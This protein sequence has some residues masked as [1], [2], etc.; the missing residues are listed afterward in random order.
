MTGSHA[1]PFGTVCRLASLG[2]LCAAG[3]YAAEWQIEIAEPMG[4]LFS[5]LQFDKLGNAHVVHAHPP[6][7]A[8]KYSFWDRALGKWFTTT[9]DE[10]AGFCSLTLDSQQRPHVSYISYGTYRVNY[11]RWNGTEWDKQAIQIRA[12]Q[13]DYYTSIALDAKDNPA[14]SF[15]EYHGMGEEHRLNLRQVSWNGSAWEVRTI[16]STKG[17]GKFNSI[18]VDSEGHPHV[19]YANVSEGTASLRYGRWNGRS[20]D[21]ELLEGGVSGYA[22]WS[23]KLALDKKD[24]PH[25]TYTDVVSRLVK[26]A[27][28]RGSKWELETVDAIEK[29]GY[30]DRNGL[31]LDDEGR[32]YISYYDAGLGQLRMAHKAEGRWVTEVVDP[33]AAGYT[34]SIGIDR[35]TIWITYSDEAQRLK[36][37]RRPLRL[38]DS[39]KETTSASVG[40]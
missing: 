5:S 16:D 20:W 6:T 35:D 7:R 29:E 32:P 21:L 34:S 14:I 12:R 27:V 33:E 38:D 3:V 28:K 11:A 30:P 17:S 24:V 39:T 8:L 40:K 25:I 1:Y 15:Y 4:G 31:A 22:A 37:A 36:S 23:V 10:T 26:Y 2:V 9:L 19:G 18:A 13:I